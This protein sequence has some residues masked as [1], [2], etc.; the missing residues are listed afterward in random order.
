[1]GEAAALTQLIQFGP[2]VVML[3]LLLWCLI[4]LAPMWKEIRLRE[5]DVREQES[6]AKGQ[7][8]GALNQLADALKD[9][10][11][12]QRRATEEIG[13]M[14]RVSNDSADQLRRSVNA[15]SERVES[16]EKETHNNGTASHDERQRP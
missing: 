7:Q 14:Q 3:A 6:V 9:I 2:T 16:L 10:A 15:L 11:V 13:I 12:E 4:R 8:A 1:M 5:L